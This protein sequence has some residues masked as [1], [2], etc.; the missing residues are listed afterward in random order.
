LKDTYTY[1]NVFYFSVRLSSSLASSVH[2]HRDI[3]SLYRNTY[4]VYMYYS[5]SIQLFS[6]YSINKSVRACKFYRC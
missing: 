3:I 2:D 1:A 5:A 4:H 6:A